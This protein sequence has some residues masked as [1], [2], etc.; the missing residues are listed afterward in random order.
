MGGAWMAIE[1]KLELS[2]VYE[3]GLATEG[4]LDFYEY[5]R[6]A[7]GFSRLISTIE[8]Y[9][10]TGRVPQKIT[11][12]MKVDLIIRAPEKGSFP[13]DILAPIIAASGDIKSI[14]SYVPLNVLLKFLLQTVKTLLPQSRDRI[15]ALAELELERDKQ[16]TAQSEQETER[17]VEIRKIVESGNATTQAALDL[18]DRQLQKPDTALSNL[19]ENVASLSSLRE[20][21]SEILDRNTELADHSSSLERIPDRHLAELTKKIRPQ[22]AELGVPLGRSAKVVSITEGRK[23]APV[24]IFDQRRIA[25]IQSR[26]LDEFEENIFIR[27][28]YY[29]RDGGYGRCDIYLNQSDDDPFLRKISFSVGANRRNSLRSSLLEAEDIGI[30]PAKV[31]YFRDKDSNITSVLVND[32]EIPL[33]V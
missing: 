18:L 1:E 15:I 9:R 14:L 30:V 21:L 33:P 27:V 5:S 13:I 28:I 2:V 7:Y 32:V 6:A 24:A 19:N 8:V 10:R 31:R 4:Q 20:E 23:R 16:R 3:G 11:R 29:D 17:I 12:Q 25:D 22:I 26:E